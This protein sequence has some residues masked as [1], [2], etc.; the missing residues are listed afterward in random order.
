MLWLALLC[1][2]PPTI[3]D[4]GADAFARIGTP[5]QQGLG[6]WALQFTPRVA[7]FEDAVVLEVSSSRRLFGGEQALLDRVR[8]ESTE[9]GCTAFAWAPT[10]IAALALARAGIANGC[11]GPLA[12]VLDC[13]PFTVLSAAR[14]QEHTLSR[15]GSRTLGDVRR[16][17]R[18][19]L[20]RRFGRAILDAL[21]R[22]YGL[23]PEAFEWLS[24]PDAF[25]A[26]LELPGRVEAADGLVFWARRLLLQ[27]SG[28]LAARHAGVRGFSLTWFHDFH[29]PNDVPPEA[30]L[31][32]RTAEPTREIEHFARLLAE[33]LAHVRLGAS[34]SDI[35]LRALDVEPLEEQSGSL[36]PDLR[37]EGEG[38]VQLLERLSARLGPDNVVRASVRSD[39]RPE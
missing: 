6:W 11:A 31:T 34:V 27:M 2:P 5:E 24:L 18:G 10:A 26:R 17:P 33:Q 20:S 30:V 21:D 7:L 1:G 14:A 3:P 37:R 32:I 9:L 22:A 39:Y 35:V 25:E 16:L 4:A 23:L 29:R 19:G 8:Q 38:A 13:L 36:L 12:Q 28:W 15:L